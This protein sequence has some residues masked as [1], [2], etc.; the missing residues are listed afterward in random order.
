MNKIGAYIGFAQKKGS[1]VY[2]LDNIVI[3][4]KKQHL[5]LACAS[6][7]NTLKKIKTFCGK[8]GVKLIV[9]NL[10]LKDMVHK[11]N[12]K[13][14]SITDKQLAEAIIANADDTNFFLSEGNTFDN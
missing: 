13:A 1:V 2:G 3:Y 4:K 9:T 5:V 14:I 7:E 11:T 10:P 8:S 6:S 12:C